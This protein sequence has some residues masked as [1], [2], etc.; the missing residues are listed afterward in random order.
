MNFLHLPPPPRSH[1]RSQ[2]N[3]FLTLDVPSTVARI[4]GRPVWVLLPPSY[5]AHPNRQY[6]VLY[7]LDGENVWSSPAGES[8]LIGAGWFLDRTVDELWGAGGVEEFILVAVP[9]RR[10]P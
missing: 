8:G 4:P 5:D 9:A 1:A 2:T 7:V 3:A 6:P 10:L